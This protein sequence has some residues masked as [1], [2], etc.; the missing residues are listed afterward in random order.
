MSGRTVAVLGPIPYDRVVG[1][2]GEVS[3]K[4]GCVL[5]TVAALSALLDEDDRILPVV[6]VR[7]SDEAAVRELLG[8][9]P[10]VDLTGVRAE[11]DRG[12]VVELRYLDQNRRLERQTHF[13]APIRPEDVEFALEADAFVC[14]PI[15]DYQVGPETLRYLREHGRGTVH[16]DGHGPTVALTSGGERRHRLWVDRDSW[17]PYV[18]VLKMNLEEAGCSWF[19]PGGDET[20]TAG[21]PLS[22]EDLPAFAA[23]CLDQGVQVVCVTLDESGCAVYRRGPDGA[24]REDLVGRIEVADVVDT[25]GCGDSFAAGLAFGVLETGDAVDAAR[26]GNAMGAQRCR[27]TVVNGYLPLAQ[28]R[29]EIA[30]AYEGSA[31]G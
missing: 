25:T 15:T 7:R 17:L 8:V 12:D 1:P 5:Y 28:T 19:P 20:T 13:M 29:A 9:Y 10:Q 26:Y 6:H 31:R 30:S 11:L 23:H 14:V 22:V 4:F 27:S 24:L 18:D 21:R 16:L 3:E 2:T